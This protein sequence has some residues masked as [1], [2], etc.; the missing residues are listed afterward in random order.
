MVACKPRMR[1]GLRTIANAF[2]LAFVP[3]NRS[4]LRSGDTLGL[5]RAPGPIRRI[6][7]IVQTRSELRKEIGFL[8]GYSPSETGKIIAEF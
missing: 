5:N 6:L 2:G 1:A 4:S 3:H 7:D 8:P